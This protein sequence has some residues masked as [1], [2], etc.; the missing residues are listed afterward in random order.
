MIYSIKLYI[1]KHTY[2]NIA[3]Y[4][5]VYIST[6]PNAWNKYYKKSYPDNKTG[7]VCSAGKDVL[8]IPFNMLERL[9]F[10]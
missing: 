7:Y 10:K 5:A 2:N 4:K 1:V 6:Y 3:Y 9:T 8:F